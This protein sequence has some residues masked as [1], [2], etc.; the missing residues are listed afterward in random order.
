M[1]WDGADDVC[2]ADVDAA[3]RASLAA[4][5]RQAR[6]TVRAD[7]AV[8]VWVVREKRRDEGRSGQRGVRGMCMR[9]MR[10][11][12]AANEHVGRRGRQGRR[13]GAG[14]TALCVRSS[15]HSSVSSRRAAS[16]VSARV[17]KPVSRRYPRPPLPKPSPG[18]P[19]ICALRKRRSKKPSE[20]YPSGHFIHT[21][22]DDAAP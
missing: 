15:T 11:R 9:R 7:A 12:A 14:G 22:G 3:I 10:V 20:L 6:G 19:A 17:P 18:V 13:R 5:D 8:R 21:Y 16:S 1:A 4:G 2:T